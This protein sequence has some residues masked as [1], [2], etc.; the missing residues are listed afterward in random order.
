MGEPIAERN[1]VIIPFTVSKFGHQYL[2]LAGM[3]KISSI[4]E[5]IINIYCET[6]QFKTVNT[7]FLPISS[8]KCAVVGNQI[9]LQG[10]FLL[11]NLLIVY[12][13]RSYILAINFILKTLTDDLEILPDS[14]N[15]SDTSDIWHIVPVQGCIAALFARKYNTNHSYCNTIQYQCYISR[16]A[17]VTNILN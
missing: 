8:E 7:Q 9:K 4:L 5:E 6:K 12:N 1:L 13:F 11:L 15:T 16:G 3:D 17:S 2:S 14:F 10:T